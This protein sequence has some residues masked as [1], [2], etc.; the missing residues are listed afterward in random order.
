MKQPIKYALILFLITSV[1]VGILGAVNEITDPIIKANEQKAEEVAMRELITEGDSFEAVEDI[2]ESTT[3]EKI[4]IAKN[5]SDLVGYI[6]KVCPTGYGGAIAMLVGIDTNGQVKG[7]SILSHGETPGFGA[8]CVKE[9]F[10]GQFKDKQAPLV[11]SKSAS[12]ENEI[13]AITGATITSDAVTQ[14]VNTAC[15]YVMDH[16][17]E[18]GQ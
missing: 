7:I 14:G 17:E 8:N 18:W 6:V 10:K 16:K 1:C 2:E 13:Q 11:V 9:S 15:Q 3:I 5:A 12:A 4:F